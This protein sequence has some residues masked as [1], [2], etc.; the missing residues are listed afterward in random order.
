MINGKIH[1]LTENEFFKPSLSGFDIVP[2]GTNSF[3]SGM[4]AFQLERFTSKTNPLHVML[5]VIDHLERRSLV[6]QT[7]HHPVLCGG[8]ESDGVE[9]GPVVV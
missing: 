6:L 9:H 4:I 3:Q 8:T 1:Y 2:K 7:L 5:N